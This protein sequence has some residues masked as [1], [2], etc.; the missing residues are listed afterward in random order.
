M[1]QSK[2]IINRPTVEKCLKQG[3]IAFSCVRCM[4]SVIWNPIWLI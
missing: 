4:G 2:S 1:F 3:I